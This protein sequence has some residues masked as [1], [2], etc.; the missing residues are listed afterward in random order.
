MEF[1]DDDVFCPLS[2]DPRAV[3]R[4]SH[5]CYQIGCR[6]RRRCWCRRRFRSQHCKCRS[7]YVLYVRANL[8]PSLQR[9]LWSSDSDFG[10]WDAIVV[11]KLETDGRVVCPYPATPLVL[12]S[13]LEIRKPYRAALLIDG[14]RLHRRITQ[15][16]VSAPVRGH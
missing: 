2:I 6:C 16:G 10:D 7:L 5:Q 13:H 15:C 11:A 3:D 1:L 14:R 9:S 12:N 4:H 8:P